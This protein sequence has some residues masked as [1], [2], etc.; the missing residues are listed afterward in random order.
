MDLLP[1]VEIGVA[2]RPKKLCLHIGGMPG[3][4]QL[5][6]M[7]DKGW[8]GHRLIYTQVVNIAFKM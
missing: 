3:V 4:H 7:Q 1:S 5:Y 8:H 2:K 6:T